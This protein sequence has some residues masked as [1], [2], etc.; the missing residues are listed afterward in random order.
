MCCLFH[1]SIIL[2]L[3]LLPSCILLPEASTE[4]LLSP[5]A[6]LEHLT[7]LETEILQS[8]LNPSLMSSRC[9]FIPV[10]EKWPWI[11]QAAVVRCWAS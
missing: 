7:Y 8:L 3:Y 4:S 9:C 5:S 11:L 2:K 1:H 10:V 6:R